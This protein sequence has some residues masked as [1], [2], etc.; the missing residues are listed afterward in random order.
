[1]TAPIDPE[2]PVPQAID[3]LARPPT[4]RKARAIPRPDG[5]YAMMNG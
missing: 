1:M 5:G 3:I 4:V 2:D